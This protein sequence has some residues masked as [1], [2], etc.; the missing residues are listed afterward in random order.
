MDDMPLILDPGLN[1]D[2][3]LDRLVSKNHL[4]QIS[5]QAARPGFLAA[6]IFQRHNLI[7]HTH[8]LRQYHRALRLT[9]IVSQP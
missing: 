5:F 7:Q 4:S 8:G 1:D 3:V 6:Q 2:I 9:R